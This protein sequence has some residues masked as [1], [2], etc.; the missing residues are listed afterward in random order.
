RIQQI[1]TP[2]NLY[3]YPYNKF[4]A[5]FI[6]TPQMNFFD[7]TLKRID[8]KVELRFLGVDKT[9]ILPY[10]M[11][12]KC[13]F[14]YLNGEKPVILGVRGEHI[15]FD[16]NKYPN[17]L[18]CR[19]YGKENLGT[20]YQVIA[21]LDTEREE[22]M[23][24]SPT[25]LTICTS[26]PE[27]ETGRVCTI[28]LD[29]TKFHF[30][31]KETE[32]NICL[33]IPTESVLPCEV[34]DGKLLLSKQEIQLPPAMV[35]G[36]GDYIVRVPVD[37]VTVADGIKVKF[38]KV[39]DIDGKALSI[40]A[41]GDNKIFALNAENSDKCK[42]IAIDLKRIT[43]EGAEEKLP[44][45]TQNRIPV[46]LVK[47]KEK[48]IDDNGKKQSRIRYY[49]STSSQKQEIGVDFINRLQKS[50][51]DNIFKKQYHLEFSAWTELKDDGFI[52]QVAEILDYG[53]EKF[54]RCTFEGEELLLAV[55]AELQAE[56]IGFALNMDEVVVYDSNTDVRIL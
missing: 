45:N 38:E 21:D 43:L 15:S 32:V 29:S 51:E 4:V 36:D 31:D 54:A 47:E 48:F 56:Q 12:A 53:K 20:D 40:F 13:D 8:D 37:A 27:I 2:R 42:E 7:C 16:E 26:I 10:S 25:G 9:M 6:G 44:L 28:S 50:T 52:C 17:K 5:G 14:T 19:L 55:P 11:F 35:V 30:F 24:Q 18:T 41:L 22:T 1:D 46:Q 39:E 34:K 3:R 49:A 33:R 23:E